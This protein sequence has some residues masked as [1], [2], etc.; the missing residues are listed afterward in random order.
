MISWL[1]FTAAVVAFGPVPPDSCLFCSSSSINKADCTEDKHPGCGWSSECWKT[2]GHHR[3]CVKKTG[4]PAPPPPPSRGL[5][6]RDEQG[7]PVDWWF[8][9]K[10]PDGFDYAYRDINTNDADPLMPVQGRSLNCTRDC[11]LGS[12]LHQLYINKTGLATVLYNDEPPPH[13]SQHAPHAPMHDQPDY[14]GDGASYPNIPKFPDLNL[15]HFTWT[16]STTYGQSFLCITLPAVAIDQSAF[17][18]RH[19]KAQIFSQNAPSWL[20]TAS[21]N[22]SLLL[23]QTPAVEAESS[24][25]QLMTKG[26]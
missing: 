12:T 18:L 3:G 20:P 11:A 21:P 17:Q 14:P 8:I 10:L 16:A 5:S 2:D 4:P 19:V 7:Q 25:T 23:Q 24:V 9:Y 22:M 6:C 13:H 26:G 15:P 1:A